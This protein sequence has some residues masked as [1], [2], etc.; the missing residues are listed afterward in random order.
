MNEEYIDTIHRYL[1]GTMDAADR[2]A[3]EAE[4][5]RN[6]VLR[7]DVEL[8]Q[9]LLNGLDYAGHRNL[10]ETIGVV[11][12]NLKL[13]GFFTALKTVSTPTLTIAHS[14]KTSVMKRILAIAAGLVA[15]AAGVFFFTQQQHQSPNPNALYSQFYQ[16]KDDTERAHQIIATLT[17]YGLAGIQS[18]T[19]TLKQALELY[20]AGNYQESLALLKSFSEAHPENDTALYYLGVIH[21]SQEHY[22]KAI[23]ILLPLSRSE[24]ALKNNALWNLGL[25]Y[26]KAENGLEDARNAFRQLSEDNSFANQR[27]ATAVL[28]QLIPK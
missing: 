7:N 6:P 11:H 3:F 14:S 23:E 24:S 15:I 8:E 10:R 25:C 4:L 17:S 27:G 5:Q 12:Q 1:N 13:E 22:A 20:E 2:K 19:D 16:P 9:A 21:M 28:E 18:D 26:L